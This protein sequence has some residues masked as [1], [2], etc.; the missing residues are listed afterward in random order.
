MT[1]PANWRDRI[2]PAA[3]GQ[4][5]MITTIEMERE[6][7]IEWIGDDLIALTDAG[8]TYARE[9]G[10]TADEPELVADTVSFFMEEIVR[11]GASTD[12]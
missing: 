4:V 8:R 12:A 5:L 6:G 1:I 11:P 10:L 3:S 7:L 2:S 9:R